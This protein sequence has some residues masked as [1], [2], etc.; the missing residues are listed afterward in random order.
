[1]S[2]RDTTSVRQTV[3][4]ALTGGGRVVLAVSGG[5]D[6][7]VLLDAAAWSVPR[8]RLIVATFDHR[9][10]PAATSAR[11]SVERQAS[12][13]GIE[14]CGSRAVSA[15]RGEAALREAR[16]N[17]LRRVASAHDAAIATAHTLDDQIETVL[18]RIM[19]GAGARGLA[20]LFAASPVIRPLLRLRRRQL[21]QYARSRGLEWVEDPSN[22]SR[23]YFRNRV[24]HDLLSALRHVDPSIDEQ[25]L[26]IG[27]KAARWRASVEEITG[28]MGIVESTAAVGLEVPQE[29][30]SGL[31][32]RSAATLWPAIAARAGVTLDRRGIER[33]AEFSAAGRVGAQ[34]QL[35]GGWEVTRSR[36]AFELRPANN[37][38]ATESP[39]ELSEGTRW[40]AWSFKAHGQ[41]GEVA[42][43]WTAWLPSDRPLSVRSW[44]SGDA[45]VVRDGAPAR[46]VKRF[47][48][49]AG[50]SGHIRA[51]WPVVLSGDQI[52]WIPGVRRGAA[53]TARPGRPGLPFICEY[54]NR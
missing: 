46:K 4:A 42:D 29:A 52:V 6:S 34:I 38:G 32:A 41:P 30:I 49:D 8:E 31:S 12:L 26:G 9:T 17:F 53:A 27:R 23:D 45:M 16:W 33:L 13:L 47:L 44:R 18:M 43:Q 54:D 51:R 3:R 15:A 25:I 36:D 48:S 35:S 40:D 37:D 20:G 50:V 28:A 39:L 7:M 11:Q 22:L 19:R 24:R 21:V 2:L 1:V 14:C 5:L 10:G